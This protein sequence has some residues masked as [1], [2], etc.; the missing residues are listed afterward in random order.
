MEAKYWFYIIIGGIYLLSRFLKKS[1]N[2][3]E[4]NSGTPT[5]RPSPAANTD[6]TK[7]KTLTFEELLREIT[8]GKEMTKQIL[9]VGQP[10]SQEKKFAEVDYDDDLKE[11]A[12]DLEESVPDYRSKDRSYEIY[13]EGKMNAFNRPS[14]EETLNVRN[15]DMKFG[16]FKAFEQEQQRN[17]LEEYTKQLQDPEG[18]KKAI[19]MSE[20]LNRKF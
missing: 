19:V 8:E 15:T 18:L 13:E 2:P 12:E 6:Q 20:I 16:K 7:P 3:A 11:E 4:Q 9:P 17:L 1:D 10:T 14:L 5:P